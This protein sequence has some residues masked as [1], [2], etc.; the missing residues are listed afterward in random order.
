MAR[1]RIDFSIKETG[2]PE[3]QARGI[4][5]GDE[6]ESSSIGDFFDKCK[7]AAKML[8][9]PLRPIRV[10]QNIDYA[11]KF[12]DTS[13]EPVETERMRKALYDELRK[14]REQQEAKRNPPAWARPL[15]PSGDR[16]G[17]GPPSKEYLDAV[18][19]AFDPDRER[20]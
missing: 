6:V 7:A 1:F 16:G 19:K 12:P 17:D 10:N 15:P 2:V 8:F 20:Y 13:M 5:F 11:D 3:D 18:K 14:M 4:R 9:D